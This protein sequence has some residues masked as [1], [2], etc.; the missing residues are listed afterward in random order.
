M[1]KA[2]SN[3]M[4]CFF[5]LGITFSC[6]DEE[7]LPNTEPE[8]E[9]SDDIIDNEDNSDDTDT[10][11]V[12]YP[13]SNFIGKWELI[14]VNEDGTSYPVETCD[15]QYIMNLSFKSDDSHL[16]KFTE[17][18]EESQE[19]KSSISWDYTWEISEDQ[20]TTYTTTDW[21]ERY[22]EDTYT[23]LELSDTMLKLKST[24]T[25]TQNGVE[26]TSVYIETFSYS[27]EPDVVEVD[28]SSYAND[29]LGKWQ[30]SSLYFDGGL[31]NLEECEKMLT[32]E[33]S[34]KNTDEK[35]AQ[36]K[37][38]CNPEDSADYVWE[39]SGN[40][41]SMSTPEKNENYEIIELKDGIMKLQ[42]KTDGLISHVIVEVYTKI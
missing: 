8:E 7:N 24:E 23:I 1:K 25:Y 16:A 21:T 41:L 29:I 26:K 6:Q 11:A 14:D 42:Y 31:T 4:L 20:F 30:F 18:I 27:G 17:Y 37:H 39:L 35:L 9:V 5:I 13:E 15:E 22:D 12:T 38:V 32:I 33:Y 19:C 40:K 34:I 10:T 2:I 36:K 3:L 28:T